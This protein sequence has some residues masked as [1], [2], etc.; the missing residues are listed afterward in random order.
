MKEQEVVIKT[1]DKKAEEESQEEQHKATPAIVKT[2]RL[3]DR[4][5]Y[6]SPSDAMMSPCSQGL[7]AKGQLHHPA[8]M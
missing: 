1:P 2:R 4:F 7:V 8:L 5:A 6:Q 3:R